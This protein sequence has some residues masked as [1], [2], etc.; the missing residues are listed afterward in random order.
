[1]ITQALWYHPNVYRIDND[2]LCSK[3]WAIAQMS[4]RI[5]LNNCLPAEVN[6]GNA[7]DKSKK[8]RL[9]V[10]TQTGPTFDMN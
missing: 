2:T 10:H 5:G 7:N 8:Y 1:M 9:S 4:I 6:W 3:I